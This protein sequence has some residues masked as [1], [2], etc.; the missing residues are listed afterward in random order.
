MKSK[1]EV[2]KPGTVLSSQKI[3]GLKKIIRGKNCNLRRFRTEEPQLEKILLEL[4]NEVEILPFLNREYTSN[5]TKRKIRAWLRKKADHPVEVWY[6]IRH[7]RIC[8]GYI[9]FKWRKHFDGACEIS[10]AIGKDYR[11]LKLGFESSKLM[12][13]HLKSLEIFPHLV[14][15]VHIK[16]KKAANN[17]RKL[18]F[19]KSNRLHGLI[20]KQ[21]YGEPAKK[22]GDRIYDLYA[23]NGKN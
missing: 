6:T 7:G 9:C 20:T 21:F 14:A 4:F 13:D 22:S 10:T 17:I 11:G 3:K 5:N 12:I 15:Y 2:K 8:A 19:A 1:T 23:T 18:G 16:N